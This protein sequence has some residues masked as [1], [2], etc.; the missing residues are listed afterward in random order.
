MLCHT[1]GD[2][3]NKSIKTILLFIL[4]FL[5]ILYF[6]Y[7]LKEFFASVAER[8][9][10]PDNN[11]HIRSTNP[12]QLGDNCF[13]LE[14]FSL[15]E[16]TRFCWPV[17]P[18]PRRNFLHEDMNESHLHGQNSSVSNAAIGKI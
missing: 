18:I 8:A 6:L 10:K 5:R 4:V 13:D 2:A 3:A 16:N 15:Q 11:Q 14:N 7:Y 17:R 9:A 12:H 1:F